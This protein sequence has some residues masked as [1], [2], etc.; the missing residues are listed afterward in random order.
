MKNKKC[1]FFLIII[2]LSIK[3]NSK[4][5]LDDNI[6]PYDLNSFLIQYS[7]EAPMAPTKDNFT[8]YQKEKNITISLENQKLKINFNGIKQSKSE[9]P[10]SNFKVNYTLNFYDQKKLDIDFI[11][12][13]LEEGTPLYTYSLLKQG[14]ETKELINWEINIKTNDKKEQIAQL[15]AEASFEDNKEVYVYNSFR[16]TYKEEEKGD[17]TF[18]FWIIFGCYIFFITITFIFMYVYFYATLEIGRNTLKV[19]NII[20]FEDSVSSQN[21]D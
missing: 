3:I 12:A 8:Y 11:S 15:I 4:K 9:N 14:E 16:F 21:V 10:D 20:T 2:F 18:Q 7:K 6:S 13:V 1:S 17:S 5:Y 19:N